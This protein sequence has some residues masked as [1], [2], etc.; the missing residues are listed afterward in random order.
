MSRRDAGAPT[1][2]ST[3]QAGH[4]WDQ[5]LP[6][7]VTFLDRRESAAVGAE[8]L[9][10]L[11]DRAATFLQVTGDP[12]S[13]LRLFE[14]AYA[15]ELTRVPRDPAAEARRLRH[16]AGALLTAGRPEHALRII[17]MV[18]EADG[19]GASP[20]DPDLATDLCVLGGVLL[21]AARSSL[22]AGSCGHQ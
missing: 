4:G 5:L 13:E 7:I 6:H 2:R 19:R 10:E 18:I 8:V 16:Y 12:E 17:T 11:A 15:V 20:V 3:P 22:T 14:R 9:G 1:S 21:A